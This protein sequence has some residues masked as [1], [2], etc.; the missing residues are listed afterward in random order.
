MVAFWHLPEQQ[1]EL[2]EQ[3]YFVAAIHCK[4]HGSNSTRVGKLANLMC[5]PFL[6]RKT[7]V[8]CSAASTPLRIGQL[9][10]FCCPSDMRCWQCSSHHQ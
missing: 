5:M 1:F 10:H 7:K 6:L 9:G 4:E 8:R 2:V 3:P